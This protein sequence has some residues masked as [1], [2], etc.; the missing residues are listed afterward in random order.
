MAAW[1]QTLTGFALG[2][3]LMGGAGLLGLMPLPQAAMVTS[4]LVV[5]NGALVLWRGW[6]E[7]DRAVLAQT[8]CGSF[9]TMLIG[10]ALLHWLAARAVG[11][12]QLL[13]GLVICAA[14]LQLALHPRPQAR[15]SGPA[16]FV[17][18]GAAGGMLSGLFATVGPPIIWNLYRQPMALASI[19]VTLLAVFV[20]NQILRL[21]VAAATSGIGL[22]VLATAAGAIPAV[23]LG[24][25]SARRW[26][27][28][29]STAAIR[30]LA[31]ALLMLSGLALAANGVTRLIG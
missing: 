10:F 14:A 1:L 30:K 19:R 23:I 28:P 3:I 16:V 26:P 21:G 17:I 31:F 12:L 11:G 9:P 29:V 15:R 20:S 27:P 5:T 13:L 18:A 8:L 7:V 4:I 22:P 6:R 24:T 25:Y 2:M